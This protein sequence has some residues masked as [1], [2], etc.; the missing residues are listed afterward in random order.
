MTPLGLSSSIVPVD[1]SKS[2]RKLPIGRRGCCLGK[3]HSRI[4][5]TRKRVPTFLRSYRNSEVRRSK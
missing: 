5:P 2:R 4:R 3:P 1:C